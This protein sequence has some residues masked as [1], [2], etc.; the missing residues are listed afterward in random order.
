[1]V[2]SL[3]RRHAR[4]TE[5]E[6]TRR[7]ALAVLRDRPEVVDYEER[8]AALREWSAQSRAVGELAVDDTLPPRAAAFPVLSDALL[9]EFVTGHLDS[10]SC[11]VLRRDWIAARPSRFGQ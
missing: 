8:V 3:G 6:T 9:A 10:R 11:A 4:D 7:S 1:M 2:A 5:V